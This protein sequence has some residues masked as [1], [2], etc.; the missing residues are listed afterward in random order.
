MEI[1]AVKPSIEERQRIKK[2]VEKY[3]KYGATR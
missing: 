3:S 1:N 2:I